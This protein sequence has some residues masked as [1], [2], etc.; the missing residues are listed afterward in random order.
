MP[1]DAE[2]VEAHDAAG[3]FLERRTEV[4][5]MIRI[6]IVED[7]TMVRDALKNSLDG[8]EDFRVIAAIADAALAELYCE[9]TSPD[10]VLM[11]VC[12]ENDSSG[13]DAAAAIKKRFPQV[14][15]VMMTG[16]P[17]V[18]FV[19]RAREAGADSFVYKDL[20]VSALSAVIRD[21]CAGRSVYPGRREEAL[22]FGEL[23]R[24]EREVLKLICDGMSRRE[25]AERLNIT[26][27]SVKTHFSNILSKT[28]YESIS[29]LAI[30]AVSNGFINTK[31]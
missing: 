1:W 17:E 29:K 22:N 24:R 8:I 26:I 30:F 31:I 10:L 11:D 28:G 4:K 3:K 2:S 20:D 25:I 12:T 15:V 18:T 23:T 5:G 16:L 13:L 14:R 6:M 27:N 9:R 19:E 21:T 7:Q